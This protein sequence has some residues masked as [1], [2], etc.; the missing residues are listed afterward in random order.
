MSA[1]TAPAMPAAAP[2]FI[3]RGT[4]AFRRTNLAF[5][6]AGF[7]TFALLYCVQPLLPAFSSGFGVTPA[8]SSLALSLPTG[9]M[10]IVMLVAG[11]VSEAL[12]RKPL[13]VASVFGSALLTLAAAFAPGWEGFLALRALLGVVLSGLP[14]IAMAYIAEEVHP[15]SSGYAM[16]LYIS[17]SAFGGLVG[18]V[19][20]GL[21]LD[22]GGWRWAMGGIATLGL[23]S[24]LVFWR[25]LP[26]SRQFRPRPLLW[27]A[28]A[29]NF[30]THLRDGGMRWLYL[31]GFLLMGSFVTIYNYI[32]YRLLAPPFSLPHSLVAMVFLVYL[33]GIGSS[34]LAGGLA[35]RF[36]RRR[37]LWMTVLALLAGLA[38]TLSE[39]L[40]LVI[41]GL[42][43]ITFGF[44]GSH[45]L[46][47]SWVGRRAGATKAQGSSLYLF[48]YYQ[49]AS[50]LGSLGGFAWAA[51]GWDGVATLV[52]AALA[53]ALVAAL[54]LARLPGVN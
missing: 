30:A 25:C 47:S 43:A 23:L 9:V 10:S 27:G 1:T 31:L 19:L 33:V 52:G 20:A 44:F 35:D 41:L 53:L 26:E 29:A 21:L 49:G 5:L 28:M 36:G 6:C 38:C 8:A 3:E 45:S 7:S 51:A 24:A 4:A 17:G 48:C 11:A 46:A 42:A 39:A 15:R 22:L 37:V 2:P 40:P 16:G 50:L 54:R 34:T 18:R 32:G 14:A 12:G 13:M